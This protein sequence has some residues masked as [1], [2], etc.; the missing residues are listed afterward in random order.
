M[1]VKNLHR[2]SACSS[3]Y[4]LA[5]CSTRGFQAITNP[6]SSQN[7]IRSPKKTKTLLKGAIPGMSFALPSNL[8]VCMLVHDRADDVDLD[9]LDSISIS[10]YSGRPVLSRWDSSSSVKDGRSGRPVLSRW[11]SSSSVNDDSDRPPQLP[12]RRIRQ[13]LS[14][15]AVWLPDNAGPRITRT[16]DEYELEKGLAIAIKETRKPRR[17]SGNSLALHVDGLAKGSLRKKRSSCPNL[18]TQV[19]EALPIFTLDKPKRFAKEVLRR[20]VSCSA[21]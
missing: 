21:A 9:S 18:F 6:F 3:A 15:D 13:P 8:Q 11:D 14:E 12:S 19:T 2:L 16:L 4:K 10:G 1:I 20:A 5:A 17:R 7:Q